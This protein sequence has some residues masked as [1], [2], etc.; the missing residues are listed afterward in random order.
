MTSGMLGG[1]SRDEKERNRDDC[2]GGE[3]VLCEGYCG[4]LTGHV[5]RLIRPYD[6]AGKIGGKGE[7]VPARGGIGARPG[8]GLV[9]KGL[10]KRVEIF[11]A[12]LNGGG[13]QIGVCLGKL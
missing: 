10:R 13:R 11:S 1:F 6:F 7:F 8:G 5:G 2:G 9:G 3:P 12:F 4:I